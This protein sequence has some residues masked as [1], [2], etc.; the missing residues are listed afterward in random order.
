MPTHQ[1]FNTLQKIVLARKEAGRLRSQPGLNP[2]Q[3]AQLDSA[4]DALVETEDLLVLGEIQNS[5]QSMKA[6]TRQL[7]QIA[8]RFSQSADTLK[9]LAER[10]ADGARALGTLADLISKAGSA[11]LV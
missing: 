9:K 7:S 1:R 10:I 4:Y 3:Q 2:D 8:D 6:T 5:V 11:G